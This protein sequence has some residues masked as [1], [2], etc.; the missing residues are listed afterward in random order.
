M[1]PSIYCH[2]QCRETKRKRKAFK[3]V[4]FYVQEYLKNNPSIL[5]THLKK[6]RQIWRMRVRLT[7]DRGPGC[8]QRWRKFPSWR[9]GICLT[10]P[11]C[12]YELFGPLV[13]YLEIQQAN[14]DGAGASGHISRSF[15]QSYRRDSQGFKI[16]L[17][18][19][20]VLLAHAQNT[21]EEIN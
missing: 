18:Q 11:G 5:V 2:R 21:D 3:H 12:G 13:T 19:L 10:I 9:G 7:T 4:C 15:E 17:L 8:L 20:A 1:V 6:R 14:P 16:C